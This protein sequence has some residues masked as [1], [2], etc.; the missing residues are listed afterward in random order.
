MSRWLVIV[1]VQL[2]ILL[3]VAPGVASAQPV[4]P[5]VATVE[6]VTVPAVPEARFQLNGVELVT[7]GQGVARSSVPTGAAHTLQL[8]TPFINRSGVNV[9]FVRWWGR[10]LRDE[11]FSPSISGLSV[12][13]NIKIQAGFRLSYPVAFEFVDQARDPIAPGRIAAVTL[14]NDAGQLETLTRGESVVLTGVRPVLERND[15]IA[16]PATYSVQ[17]IEIDGSNAVTAGEQRFVPG[18]DQQ[19]RLTVPLH[20]VRVRAS[21]LL[22]GSPL[23]RSVAMTHPDGRTVSVQLDPNGEAGMVGLVRGRYAIR[24]DAP[25]YAPVLPF[26]LSRSQTVNVRVL[27]FADMGIIVASAVLVIGGLFLTRR[28]RRRLLEAENRVW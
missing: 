9:E 10:G 5:G 6:L 21:D 27:S 7:D 14:R 11:G 3:I 23:G 19:V 24:S 25:G 28:H 4:P 8:M 22:L 15:L 13:R 18:Q 17:S 16:K 26:E 2:A 20:K 1:V 12:R